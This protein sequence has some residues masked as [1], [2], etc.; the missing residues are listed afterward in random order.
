MKPGKKKYLLSEQPSLMYS[1]EHCP[2]GAEEKL[3]PRHGEDP[4]ERTLD[5]FIL[6]SVECLVQ[7]DGR[8]RRGPDCRC[9]IN[10][11]SSSESLPVRPIGVIGR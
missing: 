4:A 7:R 2:K 1:H 8:E 5:G 10:Q 11:E 9:G 6:I 3:L